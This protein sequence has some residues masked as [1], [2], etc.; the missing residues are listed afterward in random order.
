MYVLQSFPED[1]GVPQSGEMNKHPTRREPEQMDARDTEDLVRLCP[2]L[3]GKSFLMTM[4]MIHPSCC[5]YLSEAFLQMCIQIL[6]RDTMFAR[7]PLSEKNRGKAWTKKVQPCQQRANYQFLPI[8][9]IQ[10]S[11]HSAYEPPIWLV[12]LK[13]S[14]HPLQQ[15]LFEVSPKFWQHL[16][17]L[18]WHEDQTSV[19]HL[20]SV[21]SVDARCAWE[22][23]FHTAIPYHTSKLI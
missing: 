2:T 15:L 16:R 13:S 6:K 22:G 19:L 7:F 14:L 5:Y 17:L 1:F 21:V 18:A 20:L 11:V 8:C 12:V 10:M 4:K 9:K 3:G 23:V